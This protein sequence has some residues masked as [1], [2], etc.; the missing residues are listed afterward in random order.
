MA[1]GGLGM[2]KNALEK[3]LSSVEF[4]INDS[5][6]RKEFIDRVADALMVQLDNID[7]DSKEETLIEYLMAKGLFPF[8]FPLM[9][10]YSKQGDE[11]EK[12]NSKFSEPH[13]YAR[14]SQDLKVALSEYAPV[15]KS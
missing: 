8:A 10:R 9:L 13:I 1:S 5:S 11:K 4:Q 12:N 6:E 7:T 15:G 14:T 3:L 2:N